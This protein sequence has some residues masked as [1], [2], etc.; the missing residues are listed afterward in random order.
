ME[1]TAKLLGVSLFDLA[2]YAGERSSYVPGETT[3]VGV[4]NRIKLAMDFFK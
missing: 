1:R 3:P 4:K 2:G